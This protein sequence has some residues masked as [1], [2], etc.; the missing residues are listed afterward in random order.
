MDSRR[1]N[2]SHE[3]FWKTIAAVSVDGDVEEV[4]EVDEDVEVHEMTSRRGSVM[5]VC[6]SNR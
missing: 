2:R 5:E 3:A 6:S 1:S 4:D